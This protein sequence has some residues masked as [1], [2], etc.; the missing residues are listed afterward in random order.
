MRF[1]GSIIFVM[2]YEYMYFPTEPVYC[3]AGWDS[4]G[5]SC[6]MFSKASKT[7]LQASKACRNSGGY[8]VKID[9]ADE[10]HYMAYRLKTLTQVSDI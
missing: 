7:W 2:E 8:L 3:G 1:N 5:G 6:Y 10:Q 4:Y 9:N